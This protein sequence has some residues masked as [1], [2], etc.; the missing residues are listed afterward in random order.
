MKNLKLLFVVMLVLAMGIGFGVTDVAA[1]GKKDVGT[2]PVVIP[3]SPDWISEEA[4]ENAI[5]G[6][7][8]AKLANPS[9][10]QRTAQSRA[11]RDVASQISVYA[12]ELLT[13]YASES[14]LA[15]DARSMIAIEN[16]G[17]TVTNMQLNGAR[18]QK[19]QQMSDGTWWVRVEV[20]KGD[21]LKQVGSIVNNE[22]ANY[23]EFR[24]AEALKKLEFEMGSAK[25]VPT[26]VGE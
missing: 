7:G 6:I 1:K 16:I 20:L 18:R 23:A 10:A 2:A 19:M 4:P 24:A 8:F 9:L 26:P 11:Q 14:G 5:W 21:A 17:K 12:A 22:T 3:N 15:D 25:S 13:D